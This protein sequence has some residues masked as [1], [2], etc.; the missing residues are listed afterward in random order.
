MTAVVVTV[1]QDEGG[2][3]R[4]Y[5]SSHRSFCILLPAIPTAAAP[6]AT[7]YKITM[8]LEA[9]ESTASTTEW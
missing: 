7:G 9:R 3:G 8:Y 6:V 5:K 1:K 4:L 2:T